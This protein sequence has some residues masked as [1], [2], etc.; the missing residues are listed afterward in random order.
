METNVRYS[1]YTSSLVKE[2]LEELS[3][4]TGLGRGKVIELL[5]QKIEECEINSIEDFISLK[6]RCKKK[7]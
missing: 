4:T 6:V 2:K 7:K 5:L 3:K 1:I